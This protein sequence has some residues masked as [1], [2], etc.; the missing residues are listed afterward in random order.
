MELYEL[1]YVHLRRL[2]PDIESIGERAVSAVSNGLDLH[3]VRIEKSRYTTTFFLSYCFA[4]SGDEYWAPNL[5]IRLYGDARVAEVLTG[6]LNHRDRNSDSGRYVRRHS[7][8][9]SIVS[10]WRLNRFLF[11][12]LRYCLKQGHC[13]A[14]VY[15]ASDMTTRLS[16]LFESF[17]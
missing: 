5:Q 17:R 7:A 16:S 11:K 10:R 15:S 2:I 8:M 6:F 12:W 14:P 9:D 3:Y 4:E 13:F 1:N